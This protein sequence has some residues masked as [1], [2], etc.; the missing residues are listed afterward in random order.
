MYI[1]LFSIMKNWLQ[2]NVINFI[3]NDH[4]CKTTDCHV[5]F[6]LNDIDENSYSFGG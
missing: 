4:V 2:T 3:D 1:S 5:S 6:T